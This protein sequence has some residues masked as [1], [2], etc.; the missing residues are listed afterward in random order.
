MGYAELIRTLELLPEDKRTEVLDFARFLA[1]QSDAARSV[2]RTLGDSEFGEL[3]R[4]PVE[5]PS[6]TPLSREEANA[7]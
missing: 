6:F 5:M 1:Q 4:N 3:F 2:H 7:R